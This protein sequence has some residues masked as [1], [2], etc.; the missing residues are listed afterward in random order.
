MYYISANM[1]H[2]PIVE[3]MLAHRIRRWPNIDPAMGE[4]LMFAW[5]GLRTVRSVTVYLMPF[6]PNLLPFNSSLETRYSY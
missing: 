1:R 6:S 5:T 2:S 4:Y 3:S